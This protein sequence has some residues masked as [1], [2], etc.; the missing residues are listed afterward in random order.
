MP[1]V[2]PSRGR[3][4]RPFCSKQAYGTNGLKCFDSLRPWR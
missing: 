1:I 2:M 3:P 4:A